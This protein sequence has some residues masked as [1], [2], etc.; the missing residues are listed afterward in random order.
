MN[1][2]QEL[3]DL[4]DEIFNQ[5]KRFANV[6]VRQFAREYIIYRQSVGEVRFSRYSEKGR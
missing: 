5:P 1:E 2:F 3:R 4:T 6:D